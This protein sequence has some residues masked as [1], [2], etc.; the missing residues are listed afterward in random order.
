MN[1]KYQYKNHQLII[2]DP[3]LKIHIEE[4]FVTHM[5][6]ENHAAAEGLVV[7]RDETGQVL[8]AYFEIEEKLEGQ[9]HHYYPNGK[10]E[11]EC[12]YRE[13]LLHGPSRFYSETGNCLSETWFYKDR[14]EGQSKRY[15][16]SGQLCSIERFKEG[17][18]HGKQEYYYEDGM[19]KSTLSYRNGRLD[20]EVN[21]FWPNG[22]KKRQCHFK[23]GVREGYDRMWNAADGLLDEGKYEKGNSVGLHRR[24]YENGTPQETRLYHTPQRY[25][26]TEWDPDGNIQ[27]QGVYDSSLNYEEK[28]WKEGVKS[29]RKGKWKEGR[30]YWGDDAD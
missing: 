16:P 15:Y 13:G 11:T 5:I 3:D 10:L 22:K 30:L 23:E 20:G 29:I 18:L 6:P 9:F 2:S 21:L 12:F 4:P 19:V 8:C 24:F 17:T 7:K 14:K 27:M 26:R 28:T 25:D 1:K